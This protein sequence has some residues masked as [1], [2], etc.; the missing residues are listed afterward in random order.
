[1][2]L[3]HTYLS[4]MYTS[5]TYADHEVRTRQYFIH[6]AYEV[7]VEY[8][9]WQ[10]LNGDWLLVSAKRHDIRPYRAAMDIISF[11]VRMLIADTLTLWNAILTMLQHN[12]VS[13]GIEYGSI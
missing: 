5:H 11:L 7:A 1:M 12:A 4:I 13:M 6:T 9:L 8:E 10:C 3:Y 2:T